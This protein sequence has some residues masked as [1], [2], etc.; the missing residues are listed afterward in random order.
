MS[1]VV[2][3]G[4]ENLAGQ[5]FNGLIVE[6]M[7]TR[8]PVV[9]KLVCTKCGGSQNESHTRVRYATCRN[10]NCNRAPLEQRSTLAQTGQRIE[11]IRSRD[12]D[13]ARQ[14]QQES[15][16]QQQCKVV[17]RDMPSDEAMRNADPDSL[18]RHLDYLEDK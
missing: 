13:G 12:S 17:W 5:E 6:R 2:Y 14:F 4:F 15:T 7:I 16:Q 9:W 8:R 1:T 10:T 3:N 11:G 18:R